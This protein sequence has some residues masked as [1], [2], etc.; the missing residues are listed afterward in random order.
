MLLLADVFE[1]FRELCKQFYDLD[2]THCFTA[3]GL[4]WQACLKMTGVEFELFTDIDMLLFIEEGVRGGVSMISYRYAKA[5]IPNTADYK[6]DESHQF[7]LY[8]LGF[9]QTLRMGYV[10]IFTV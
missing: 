10:S 8:I 7:I 2:P 9:E 4:S 6:N 3:P 5:N 1:N